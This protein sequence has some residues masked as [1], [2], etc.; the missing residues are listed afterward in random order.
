MHLASGLAVGAVILHACLSA[1]IVAAAEPPTATAWVQADKSRVRLTGGRMASPA[2]KGPTLVAGVEIE[3][4]EGWK[5]YWR[6]PGSSGVPP[7]F[8]WS[9]SSN[10]AGARVLFPAPMR[11]VESDGDTIGYKDAVV[12]P[13]EL[14]AKDPSKPVKLEVAFEYG[15]C[16]EICIPVELNLSLDVPPDAAVVPTDTRLARA[17]ERVPQAERGASDP[18]VT[19]AKAELTGDK[20]RI[21]INASF[22][23]GTRGA[24]LFAEA[25][26]GLWLPLPKKSGEGPANA[27]RFEIDLNDGADVAELKGK[28][29]RLTLVS[30]N[31]LAVTTFK[32]E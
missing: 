10:L 9:K 15:I 30:D 24:D 7:R 2:G 27:V 12:F 5:T 19:S 6:N 28:T 11:F 4:A 20:P 14:M 26:D 17:L 21:I 3:M 32:V 16:K 31:G 8:D 22:P 23:A 18:F 13:I 29:L 1:P 25:P